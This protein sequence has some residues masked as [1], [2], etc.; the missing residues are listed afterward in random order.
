MV[1]GWLACR[2]VRLMDVGA[3][4]PNQ[5]KLFI[6][7]GSIILYSQLSPSG[8]VNQVTRNGWWSGWLAGLY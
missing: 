7:A 8:Q 4:I 5:L 3:T 6:A 1:A 2:L